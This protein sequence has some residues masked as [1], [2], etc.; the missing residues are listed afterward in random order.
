MDEVNDRLRSVSNSS[1]KFPPASLNLARVSHQDQLPLSPSYS[2][3]GVVLMKI[4][5][6]FN[7]QNLK[8]YSPG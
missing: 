8:V 3:S 4:L 6:S 7:G 2:M 5:A 1:D